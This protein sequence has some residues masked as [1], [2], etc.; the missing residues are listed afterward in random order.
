MALR[1]RSDMSGL[2]ELNRKRSSAT[3]RICRLKPGQ[4]WPE[5]EIQ[6]VTSIS[7]QTLSEESLEGAGKHPPV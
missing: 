5:D 2:I 3:L 4:R 1:F 6:E 7:R